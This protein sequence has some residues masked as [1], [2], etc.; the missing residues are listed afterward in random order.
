MNYIVL[1]KGLGGVGLALATLSASGAEHVIHGPTNPCFNSTTSY[2]YCRTSNFPY[3]W[4]WSL[5]GDGSVTDM[6]TAGNC[7]RAQVAVQRNPVTLTFNQSNPIGVPPVQNVAKHVVPRRCQGVAK[8]SAAKN[9]E[10]K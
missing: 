2:Q 5:S 7:Y 3:Y 8:P 10:V 1:L 4:H 6:G 9:G